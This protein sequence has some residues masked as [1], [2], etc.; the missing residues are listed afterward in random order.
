[1]CPII[2]FVALAFADNTFHEDLIAERLGSNKLHS[3][4]NPERRI[5]IDFKFRNDILDKPIF[6]TYKRNLE[7]I[8]VHPFKT[9]FAK[10]ISDESKR[11]GQRAGL[12]YP[13]R[14]YCLR[15]EVGTELTGK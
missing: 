3:F 13:F 8:S 4:Q 7:G 1:M 6:R 15:R 11:L 12:S 2:H 9:L 14:P 5:T 10:S